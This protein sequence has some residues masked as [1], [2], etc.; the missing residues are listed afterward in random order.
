[1]L[2]EL[3]VHVERRM[4]RSRPLMLDTNDS[5]EYTEAVVRHLYDRPPGVNDKADFTTLPLVAC[6]VA[7]LLH[8]GVGLTG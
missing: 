5:A 2:G 7:T 4:E 1:M 3:P 6:D 8:H